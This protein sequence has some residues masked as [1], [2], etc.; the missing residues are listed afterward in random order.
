MCSV[1]CHLQL[2]FNTVVTAVR[3][4]PVCLQTYLGGH[5][6][7]AEAAHAYDRAALVYWGENGFTNVGVRQCACMNK[8]EPCLNAAY[9]LRFRI[10]C[11]MQHRD[12]TTSSATQCGSN[13]LAAVTG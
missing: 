11:A 5:W 9:H 3:V 1:C 6:T 2:L 7:E 10:S 12:S 13:S 8:A 4:H